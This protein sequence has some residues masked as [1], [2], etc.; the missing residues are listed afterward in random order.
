MGNRVVHFEMN[1]PDGEA[2]Q[3]FY[4]DLFGWGMRKMTDW[5]YWLVDTRAGKGINGGI[6]QAQ[7]GKSSITFYAEDADPPLV[8]DRAA[9]LGGEVATPVT[10]MGMVVY[11]SFTDPDGLLVGVV[12]SA[13]PAN[14][15][16]GPTEGDGTPVN[17]FEVLG[18]DADRTQK[19]YTEL[20]GW[21]LDD[22]GLPGY[23]LVDTGAG[24]GAIKGGLGSGE[25]SM[26]V[27][28]YAE[29]AD[30]E[31]AL[32]R[33]EELGATRV[34]GPNNVGDTLTGAFRDPAGNVFGVFSQVEGSG[35]SES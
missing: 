20:F 9:A 35:S 5:D 30:V 31:P 18:S 28:V 14:D 6:G 21:N 19:Y 13:D 3:R 10:D 33:A 4:A 23:R 16:G 17:W 2:L 24:E 8:I 11:G 15:P 29:V 1:G 34:Y 26:W 22:S 25:G 12:K 32:A 27:T 7:D